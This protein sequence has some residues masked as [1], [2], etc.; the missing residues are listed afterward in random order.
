MRR[1]S[2]VVLLLA[3]AQT[4]AIQVVLANKALADFTW[5]LPTLP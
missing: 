2:L 3:V 1:R 5:P 4:L